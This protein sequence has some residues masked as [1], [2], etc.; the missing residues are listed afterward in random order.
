MVAVSLLSELVE[1]GSGL[2]LPS[3]TERVSVD[4]LGLFLLAFPYSLISF[5]FPCGQEKADVRARRKESWD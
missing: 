4:R 5:V 1:K 2:G 3:K